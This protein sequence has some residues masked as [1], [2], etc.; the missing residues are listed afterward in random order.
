MAQVNDAVL[1]ALAD[2][3]DLLNLKS[4]LSKGT[5]EIQVTPD[6]NKAIMVGLTAAQVAQRGPG[7][8]RRH[9]RRPGQL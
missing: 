5:A 4:D 3:A 7:R 2:N 9:R 6:P 8:A 1:A